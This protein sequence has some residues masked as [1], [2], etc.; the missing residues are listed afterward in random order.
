MTIAIL[1]TEAAIL[2][3]ALLVYLEIESEPNRF[4]PDIKRILR[5]DKR[6]L[7]FISAFILI[8]LT[9]TEQIALYDLPIITACK[10]VLL[11]AGLAFFAYT[12]FEG[13][14][15]P[16]RIVVIMLITRAVFY[17][18][19]LI[20]YGSD[21]WEKLGSSMLSLSLALVFFVVGVVGLKNA[22]GMGDIKLL[23]VLGL[24]LGFYCTFSAV[25]FGLI[26]LFFE[27]VILL[28]MK[29]KTKSD[30]IAFAPA[31]FIGALITIAMTGGA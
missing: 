3:F 16:N 11:L 21:F 31:L 22:I 24:Y 12:D 1:Y 13:H 8:C 18:A 29:K 5:F 30:A 28:I 19:E 9:A 2:L 15:I 6:L 23:I 20:Y 17:V 14:R 27:A 10:N 25:F 4:P 7:C 26:I